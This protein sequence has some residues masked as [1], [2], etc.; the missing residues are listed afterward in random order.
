MSRTSKS[1]QIP[2]HLLAEILMH[3]DSLA[4][5]GSLIIFHFSLYCAFIEDKRR[6]FWAVLYNQLLLELIQSAMMVYRATKA[7]IDRS[8]VYYLERWRVYVFDSHY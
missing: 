4:A 2:I 3:L 6:I 7:N 1:L 8:D 5:L